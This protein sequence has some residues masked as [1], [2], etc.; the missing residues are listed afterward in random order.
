MKK[1]NKAKKKVKQRELLSRLSVSSSRLG[2]LKTV[3]WGGE[4]FSKGF[5]IKCNPMVM[6]PYFSSG[7]WNR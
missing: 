4:L 6:L 2:L 5:L 3:K 1:E 7:L